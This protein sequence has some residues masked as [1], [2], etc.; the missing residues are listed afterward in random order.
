MHARAS[1]DLERPVRR[2]A[3]QDALDLE[4]VAV[5]GFDLRL[6]A[7]AVILL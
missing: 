4:T 7:V 2:V 1:D 6:A 5:E 3:Q